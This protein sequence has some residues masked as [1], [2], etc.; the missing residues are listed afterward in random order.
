MAVADRRRF[1]WAAGG[2][3]TGVAGCASRTLPPPDVRRAEAPTAPPVWRLPAPG[4]SWTYAQH[5]P[6]NAARLGE[7]HERVVSHD[8]ARTVVERRDSQGRRAPDEVHAE[9]G[10]LWIDPV[11]DYPLLFERPMPLWLQDDAA[12]G[13]RIA[14]GHYRQ[15]GGSYRYAIQVSVRQRGWA[16]VRVPAGEFHAVWV[17][18]FLRL[19]HEDP[20]RLETVRR[21]RLW[22]VPA[23]GRWVLRETEGEYLM[24]GGGDELGNWQLEDRWRWELLA[25]T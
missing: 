14:H 5:N 17:E 23:L 19:A 16:R 1:L 12:G 18:R 20:T 7:W 10:L 4:Q 21:D 13:W 8:A 15:E 25:W 22:I 6:F 3:V 24:G 2:L 9:W 11:W